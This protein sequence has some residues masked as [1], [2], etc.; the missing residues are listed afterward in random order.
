[1]LLLNEQD[2][3]AV[4]LFQSTWIHGGYALGMTLIILDRKSSA[5]PKMEPEETHLGG[6]QSENRRTMTFIAI[7]RETG[8]P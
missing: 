7:V 4:V 6:I 3:T 1:M 5:S 8:P 2:L